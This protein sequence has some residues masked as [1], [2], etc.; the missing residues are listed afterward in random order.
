MS[1][2]LNP[3]GD[4]SVEAVDESGQGN[5][6]EPTDG[7]QNQEV[8]FDKEDN[9]AKIREHA[10]SLKTDLTESKPY[11][12][13]IESNF[14]N[15]DSARIA[16]E[17]YSSYA[18]ENFNP[19]EF[20]NSLSKLSPDR[21]KALTEKLAKDTASNIASEQIKKT[22]GGEVS[23]ADVA[24]FR[25]YRESK[26]LTGIPDELRFNS[27]GTP[28]SEEELAPIRKLYEEQAEI[29]R[30]LD[31]GDIEKREA[32]R[33]AAQAMKEAEVGQ[34]AGN[35]LKVLEPEFAVYG[36]NDVDGDSPE[37]RQNKATVR[38]IIVSGITNQ[39]LKDPEGKAAYDA[40]VQHIERGESPLAKRYEPKIEKKL[41]TLMRTPAVEK[42]MKVFQSKEAPKEPRPEISNSGGSPQGNPNNGKVADGNDIYQNLVNSGKLKP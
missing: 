42:L 18:G 37:V 2:N 15:L 22:F 13:F 33:Q 14:G 23:D 6:T 25:K 29:K 34:F 5:P 21:V 24:E 8:D 9:V 38:E 12:E 3:T 30:R 27:D 39:F 28:K 26:A 4:E 17:V 40:A 20:I 32:E 36:L 10:K 1:D 19:D 31:A 16:N 7:L 11:R 35:R 41:L